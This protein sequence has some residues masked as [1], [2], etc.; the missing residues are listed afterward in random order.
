M[1][2]VRVA[3][4]LAVQQSYGF[5][6]RSLLDLDLAL[7]YSLPCVAERTVYAR[8]PGVFDNFLGLPLTPPGM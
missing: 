2:I 5:G 1:Q 7:R 6:G 4:R 8:V 3:I